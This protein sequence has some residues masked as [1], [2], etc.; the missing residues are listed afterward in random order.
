MLFTE[1]TSVACMEFMRLHLY[2]MWIKTR[3]TS[4]TLGRV[5]NVAASFLFI[6]TRVDVWDV[7]YIADL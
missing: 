1:H 2:C 7:N 6:S 4:G 5:D 3:G